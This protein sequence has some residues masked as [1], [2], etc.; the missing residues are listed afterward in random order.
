MLLVSEGVG[1]RVERGPMPSAH[2][3]AICRYC[4][5]V[6]RKAALGPARRQHGAIRRA[7]ACERG[8]CP[9]LRRVRST[10]RVRIESPA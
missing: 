2:L 5:A 10:T 1:A 3:A 7:T 8:A 9:T 4:L 6:L